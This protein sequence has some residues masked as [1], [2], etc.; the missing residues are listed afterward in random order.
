MKRK[1]ISLLLTAAMVT[2]SLMG[3]GK[4]DAPDSAASR[5]AAESGTGSKTGQAGGCKQVI[6]MTKK[7]KSEKF[8]KNLTNAENT[9]LFKIII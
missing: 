2:V 1:I 6:R 3:C 4:A 8:R 5:P 9:A 7:L